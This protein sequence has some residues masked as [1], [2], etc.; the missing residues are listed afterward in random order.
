MLNAHPNR[1]SRKR[2]SLGRNKHYQYVY[3]KGKSYPSR[4]MV[5]VYLRARDIKVGYSVSGKVGNAVTRNRLRRMLFEDFRLLRKRLCEG[6]YIFVLRPS[7]KLARHAEL[8]ADMLALLRRARL[9]RAE[10]DCAP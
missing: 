9:I 4:Y 7:A 5:L 3:R 10:G 1:L 2:Y 8:T 6:K